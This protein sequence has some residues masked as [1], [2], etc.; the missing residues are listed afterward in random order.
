MLNLSGDGNMLR[1][2]ERRI[3]RMNCGH[4]DD[5]GMCRTGYSNELSTLFGELTL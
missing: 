2:F 1:I 3:L 4:I 5:N